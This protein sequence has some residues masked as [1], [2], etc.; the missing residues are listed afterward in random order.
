MT[1][2]LDARLAREQ[3]ASRLPSVVAGVVRD[4]ALAWHGGAGL[5][6]GATPGPDTQYRCGSITKTFVAVQ[7]LRLRDEGRVDLADRVEQHL[8]GTGVGHATLAQ[9]LSHTAGLPAE[10]A[11]PWWERSP[12]TTYAELAASSTTP[13][14]RP[15]R[16]FHYSNV[17]FGL[18]GELVARHRGVPWHEALADEVLAPLGMGRTTTGPVAPAADGVAVH[19][20]ADVRHPEPAHDAAA[21]GPAGQLWST[22]A[23]LGRWAAF[24]AGDTGGV[25][26]ADTL[27]EM[28]EPQALDDRPGQPWGAAHGLGVQVWND[29]G[30]RSRGHGGSMP[31]FLAALTVDD[32]SGDGVVVLA[33]ATAGLSAGLPADLLGVLHAHEPPVPA[34]WTPAAVPASTLTLLGTWY[35]GPRPLVLSALPGGGLDLAP[36]GGGRASRFTPAGEEAWTGRD[37]Y[38]AGEALRVHRR[39][40]GTLS[41]LD[42]ASFVLTREPYDPAVDV[43]GYAEGPHWS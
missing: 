35:W 32:A 42:L 39:A 20:H 15:G 3:A 23:D 27:A 30:R 12:G 6:G 43:P 7:V 40:D 9:L 41:H 11:G 10:T 31:G 22:V 21:M 25:L 34:P 29:G 16:R 24:W 2:A 18:L 37:G 26:A 13:L 5:V 4:G 33:N 8:P 36:V 19:P 14:C 17:G 1:A 38:Y 28:V